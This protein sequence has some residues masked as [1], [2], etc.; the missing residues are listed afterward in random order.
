M[1][2]PEPTDHLGLVNALLIALVT[3]IGAFVVRRVSA[4]SDNAGD[5]L[6]LA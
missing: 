2:A 6:W 5:A 4:A 3:L 1:E